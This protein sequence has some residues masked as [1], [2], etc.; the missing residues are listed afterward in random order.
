MPLTLPT[1]YSLYWAQNAGGAY[2]HAVPDASQIGVTPGAASYNDGFVPL[3]MTIGGTPPFGQ[4]MNG[5]LRAE[6]QWC[7]WY[8]AGGVVAYDSAFQT[9]VGGYP[10]GAKVGSASV[11]GRY[12]TTTT[13]D[14]ATDPDG[15]GAGWTGSQD[16]VIPATSAQLTFTSATVLTLTPK[17][18]GQL[19]IASSGAV[20]FNYAVPAA[21]TITNAGLLAST[22]YYA[23]A[24]ISGGNM[25][26]ELSTTGYALASNGMPQKSGDATRTCVGMALTNGSS[27][28][29]SQDGSLWV[30]SYFQ[31][32]LQRSRSQFSADRTT[33][34]ATFVELNTEIRNN[35]LVWSGEQVEFH[36]TGAFACAANQSAATQ[37]AFDGTTGEQESVAVASNSGT[38]R[39]PCAINGVKTGL[40]EGNHY[41]TLLGARDAGTATWYSSNTNSTAQCTITLTVGR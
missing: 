24:A 17:V 15:G 16:L 25:I 6:T 23:Y 19:W 35:V 22:L 21:L 41:A 1:K 30:R 32:Q 7:Q 3:N 36:T 28:F 39:G 34:S 20:G 14:N 12:W 11:V 4:D 33:T 26:L 37:I 18:G 38:N 40:S 13:A 29:V 8:Q 9:A 31:R 2:V 27:Q 10:I 5:A